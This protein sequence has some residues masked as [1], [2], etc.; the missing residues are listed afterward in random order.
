VLVHQPR[1]VEE[2]GPDAEFGGLAHS[3][4]ISSA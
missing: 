2:E 4:L 1:L 3:L